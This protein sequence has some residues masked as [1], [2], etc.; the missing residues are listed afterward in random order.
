MSQPYD[1]AVVG[2]GVNGLVAAALLARA[3]RRVVVLERLPRVGGAAVTVTPFAGSPAR[4]SPY[5]DA[6]AL[7]PALRTELGLRVDTR[8]RPPATGAAAALAAAVG[9]TL[10]GPLPREREV[11]DAVDAVDAEAWE[12]RDPRALADALGR[13]EQVVGGTGALA[14]A[15]AGAATEA[16]V[17]LWLQTGVSVLTAHDDGV[18]VAFGGPQGPGSLAAGHVLAGV[19]PWVL[20][21][22]LGG[23]QDEAVKPRGA[24]LRVDLLVDRL[25]VLTSGED[26]RGDV[27]LGDVTVTAPSLTDPSLAPEGQ[28]TLSVVA[29]EDRDV[30]QV[31]WRLGQ[32]VTEPVSVVGRSVTTPQEAEAEL[33]AP[34]G[35]LHHGGLAWPWAPQ[36]ARLDTP[37]EQWGVQT[38]H[39]R[40]L[41]AG[42]GARR[43]ATMT[44]VAGRDAAEAVLAAG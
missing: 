1:V 26:L 9:P 19:A 32:H 17:E 34:G 43:G 5:G 20:Q 38:G 29:D 22:L 37:A 40:V 28:H 7:P 36:R 39:P 13:R 4:V 12:A 27:R 30:D 41:L 8:E 21:I 31:L 10:D 42:A 16:G 11:R 24:W 2:A 15:L 25:P 14:D 3:D 23:P 35:D 33:A 18:E 6:V 44:G